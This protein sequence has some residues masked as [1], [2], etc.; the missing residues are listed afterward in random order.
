MDHSLP[1]KRAAA[2]SRS[3]A[4]WGRITTRSGKVRRSYLQPLGTH[5]CVIALLSMRWNQ[6]QLVDVWH[7]CRVPGRGA[8]YVDATRGQDYLIAEGG[9]DVARVYGTTVTYEPKLFFSQDGV[10]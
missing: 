1:L 7:A 10:K 3:I 5:G 6:R 9:C 8:L 4:L 2:G